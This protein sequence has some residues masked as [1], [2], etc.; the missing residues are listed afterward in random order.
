M[1]EGL[2]AKIAELSQQY[3][4]RLPQQ[5]SQIVDIFQ[6]LQ[7][8]WNSYGNHELVSRLHVMKG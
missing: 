1:S 3:R 2:K 7:E 5:F 4:S 8:R 6:K